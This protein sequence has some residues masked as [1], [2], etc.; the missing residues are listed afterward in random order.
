MKL[1]LDWLAGSPHRQ[2][3][4]YFRDDLFSL[5][6]EDRRPPYRWFLIGP[7]RSGTTI[8]IDPLATSAWNTLLC[9]RKLYVRPTF[10]R[11]ES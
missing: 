9:G 2:V 11:H 10:P 7:R 8:H 6:G 5:V 3:P 1:C 4:K